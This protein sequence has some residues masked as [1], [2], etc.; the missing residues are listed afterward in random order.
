MKN[1]VIIGFIIVCAV[2][3]II[4]SCENKVAITPVAT[5]SVPANCDTAK[6]TYSGGIDTIINTQCAVS[7]CH[8]SRST[9]PDFTSYY[10]LTTY[11]ANG[12]TSTMY[13]CLVNGNP[14]VMPNVPQP[15]WSSNPCL[16][17]KLKQWLIVGAPQ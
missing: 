5:N 6:L 13:T 11:I 3:L 17:A 10:N 2:M 12:K 16:L 7:G 1:K 8:V 15:G 14:Y 9:A 4:Q